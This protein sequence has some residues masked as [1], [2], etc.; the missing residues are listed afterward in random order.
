MAQNFW[1]KLEA[2]TFIEIPSHIKI[3]FGYIKNVKNIIFVI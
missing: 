1:E 2:D 3:G